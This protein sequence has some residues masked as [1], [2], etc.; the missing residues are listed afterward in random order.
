[1]T[2]TRFTS[3]DLEVLPEDTKRYEIIDGELYVSRQPTHPH[4]VM[5]FQVGFSLE[6]WN[7]LTGAGD[8]SLAPGLVFAE[9]DDV[10]P[11]VAW[12]AKDRLRDLLDEHGHFRAAP[13]LVVEV[14]SPG[15]ANERRD[16]EAKLA[17]YSRRGV[18]EYWIVDWQVREFEIYRRHDAALQL[19]ATLSEA[20]TLTSPLLPGFSLALSDLFSRLL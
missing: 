17:L 13:D 1:M 11:D 20:D 7:R 2:K 18:K 12:V 10:V 3:R 15:V 8:V 16:R 6:S 4:Q 14:L 9:D 5:C 19:A